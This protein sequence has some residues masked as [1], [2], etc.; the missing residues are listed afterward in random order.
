MSRGLSE[1]LYDRRRLRGYVR[2]SRR[3]EYWRMRGLG[4]GRCH[5][6]AF[7]W[8]AARPI[9]FPPRCPALWG[10]ARRPQFG[11]DGDR[12]LRRERLRQDGGRRP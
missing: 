6:A 1:R 11:G 3:G 4:A 8:L 10:S 7:A 2:E 12:P 5:A 9:K